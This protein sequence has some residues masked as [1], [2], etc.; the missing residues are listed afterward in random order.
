MAGLDQ[1]DPANLCHS[2]RSRHTWPGLRLTPAR[3]AR[4][5]SSW[6]RTTFPRDS[7]GSMRPIRCGR[8]RDSADRAAGGIRDEPA[9]KLSPQL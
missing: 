4:F 2:L 5:F 7:H 9:S 8:W 6:S 1:V 3:P